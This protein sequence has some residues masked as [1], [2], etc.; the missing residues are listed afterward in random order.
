M[1]LNMKLNEARREGRAEGIA[2]GIVEGIAKGRMETLL[3]LI[4]LDKLSIEDAAK[5]AGMS[6]SDFQSYIAEQQ[7]ATAN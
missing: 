7:T 5:L 3:A 2:E 1:T 4:Q 6:V